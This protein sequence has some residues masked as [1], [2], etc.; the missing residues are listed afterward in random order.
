MGGQLER[1]V[2]RARTRSTSARPS[3]RAGIRRDP[4]L[5]RVEYFLDA[6]FGVAIAGGDDAE[7]IDLARLA[8]LVGDDAPQAP[9]CA[10]IRELLAL[11]LA[12]PLGE[13]LTDRFAHIHLLVGAAAIA[14]TPDVP[15]T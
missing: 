5:A 12:M 3:A 1:I 8:T 6:A 9:L 7:M 11:A 13:S 4:L 2:A 10:S 14:A 15:V